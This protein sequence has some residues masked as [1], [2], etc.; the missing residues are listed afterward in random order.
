MHWF[1]FVT[2]K[3][4][5]EKN[6]F[7]F[8]FSSLYHLQT[9]I[10]WTIQTKKLL[11]FIV[12]YFLFRVIVVVCCVRIEPKNFFLTF[13]FFLYFS[14]WIIIIL[15]ISYIYMNKRIYHHIR[16]CV[17]SIFMMMMMMINIVY[18]IWN[19]C[20]CVK[21][22]SRE[23]S[24]Y[25]DDL[26]DK[27]IIIF[28]INIQ[29]V[30]KIWLSSSVELIIIIVFILLMILPCVLVFV[31]INWLSFN[32]SIIHNNNNKRQSIFLN[33]IVFVYNSK[34]TFFFLL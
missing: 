26:D 27:I 23:N 5:L 18:H 9:S 21:K 29:Q 24:D 17:S 10:K 13:N 20:V 16:R 12:Y 2:I 7:F 30:S 22:C 8:S 4:I 19:A 1:F 25:D 28:H 15:Y 3:S 31:W 34:L 14:D 32:P 11:F 6:L 33:T